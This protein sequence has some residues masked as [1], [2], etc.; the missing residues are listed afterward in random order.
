MSP[1]QVVLPNGIGGEGDTETVRCSYG[2]V[3]NHVDQLVGPLLCQAFGFEVG[4]RVD[5]HEGSIQAPGDGP[6]IVEVSI[7]CG[8][9][10]VLPSS[11]EAIGNVQM[12]IHDDGGPGKVR[13]P[14]P[15]IVAGANGKHPPGLL[16]GAFPDSP[17]EEDSGSPPDQG[18]ESESQGRSIV[19][20]VM[21]DD[22]EGQAS[23][24]PTDQTAHD[25][26]FP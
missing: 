11:L 8:P 19:R 23:E 22:G 10:N 5:G 17:S 1:T 26:R 16:A 4:R 2:D 24:R 18:A 12:A 9:R 3:P 14:Q 7:G 6:R 20:L 21:S 25:L 13:G 15:G